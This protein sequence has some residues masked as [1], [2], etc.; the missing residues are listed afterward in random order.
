MVWKKENNCIIVDFAI[1]YDTRIEQKEK[2]KVDKYQDLKREL[3]IIW[4]MRVKV[5]P[6]VIGA[7]GTI[8]R[9]FIATD[10]GQDKTT[11]EWLRKSG[12]KKETKGLLMAAQEQAIRRKY[13]RK[14]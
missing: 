13:I 3:Q 4:N 9:F 10:N 5:V 6:I 12:I 14:S 7:L 11:W 8:G 1:P 2:E